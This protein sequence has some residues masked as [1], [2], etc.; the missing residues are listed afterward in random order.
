LDANL[1]SALKTLAREQGATLY[2]VLLSAFD[3]LL[4][5][6]TG[7][8]DLLVG[9]P[10]AGRSRAA[11]ES[12]VGL[13]TNPVVLRADL[14]GNPTFQALLTQNRKTVLEALEHQDYPTV[15]LVERLRLP[16]DASRPPLCQVMFVLDKPHRIA[17]QEASGLDADDTGLSMNLAGLVLESLPL[18][19]RSA[20]MDLVMLIIETPGSMAASIRYNTELFE[21]VTI[22]HMARQFVLVLDQIVQDPLSRLESLRHLLATAERQQA[23][24]IR[25]DWRE[26]HSRRLR[27]LNREARIPAD[28]MHADRPL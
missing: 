20:T 9:S 10:M 14:S 16:R 18:E 3:L 19:R 24:G 4:S 1:S 25:K 27:L 26:S 21:A 13:F 15:L 22:A 5:F 6:Y 17:Q 8:D 28:C 11:F 23:E 7:Q 2:M 12:I